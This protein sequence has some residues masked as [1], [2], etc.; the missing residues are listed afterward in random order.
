VATDTVNVATSTISSTLCLLKFLRKPYLLP[1]MKMLN[2]VI[3]KILGPIKLEVTYGQKCLSLHTFFY[4]C[5][6]TAKHG[7]YPFIAA[8]G[9]KNSKN[10]EQIIYAC[11]GSLVSELIA[12]H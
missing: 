3:E 2:S 6:K 12:V 7:N 10:S 4:F 8:I 1:E 11:G 5:G 9:Y